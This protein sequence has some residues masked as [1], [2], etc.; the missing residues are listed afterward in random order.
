[1]S[2]PAQT[3]AN[4]RNAQKSTGPKTPDGKAVS[5]RNAIKH[6]V[7][8]RVIPHD[9]PGFSELLVGLYQSLKPQ[10][11]LQ[12]LLVDQIGVTMLRLRRIL[13]AEQNFLHIRAG[14]WPVGPDNNSRVVHDFLEKETTMNII[15]YETMLNRLMQ[16]LLN[17]Y[18]D[19][20]TSESWERIRSGDC[21]YLSVKDVVHAEGDPPAN[22]SAFRPEPEWM[23]NDRR[24]EDDTRPHVR[25]D[26]RELSYELAQPGYEERSK[27]NAEAIH[28]EMAEVLRAR[29]QAEQASEP[30]P[31][32]E[33]ASESAELGS[34]RNS[35]N[36]T[37]SPHHIITSSQPTA[38]VVP[39]DEQSKIENQKSKIAARLGS[40]RKKSSSRSHISIG[41]SGSPKLR[42]GRLAAA[43]LQT[44]TA[45]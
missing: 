40:F 33:S 29:Q 19:I 16:R 28:K 18:H 45:V 5:S 13:A 34:F 25:Y 17:N 8:A 42:T 44:T 7:L 30:A 22:P 2:T 14:E 27:A 9:A 4:R 26:S 38:D 21:P 1:M 6:G 12:R 41:R 32:P 37:S 24:E 10:D 15:R 11:E 20:R 35:D 39:H 23:V 43:G 3:E 31:S 36:V